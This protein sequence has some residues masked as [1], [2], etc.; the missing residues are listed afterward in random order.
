MLTKSTVSTCSIDISFFARPSNTSCACVL[1]EIAYRP[2]TLNSLNILVTTF[3][4]T[5]LKTIPAGIRRKTAAECLRQ[6][7]QGRDHILHPAGPCVIQRAAAER[8]VAG[9]KDHRAVDHVGIVDDALAQA[10]DADIRDRQDQPVDHFVG[11]LRS[12]R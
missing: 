4:T 11:G 9:A 1:A 10:G 3:E 6:R 7:A 8:R 2:V 5:L 12:R